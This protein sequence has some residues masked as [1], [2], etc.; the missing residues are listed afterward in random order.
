MA[1]ECLQWRLFAD[2]ADANLAV[3][4]ARGKRAV[5]QP[6]HIQRRSCSDGGKANHGTGSHTA[7]T[8][9]P[10]PFTRHKIHT[11]MDD[12]LLFDG[13]GGNVPHDRRV[14]SAA[15]QQVVARLV[16]LQ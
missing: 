13:S 4:G 5:I 1:L 9:L 7:S 3:G 10:P 15:A 12:K 16:E 11:I 6:V 14:V 8:P 2:F